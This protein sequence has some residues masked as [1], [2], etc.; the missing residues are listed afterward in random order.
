M[1][2]NL[3]R[4]QR[5]GRYTLLVLPSRAGFC[6]YEQSDDCTL[7]LKGCELQEF[8]RHVINEDGYVPGEM[9]IRKEMY[10][11]LA[12]Y[13]LTLGLSKKHSEIRGLQM[14]KSRRFFRKATECELASREDLLTSILERRMD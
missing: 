12:Q 2:T 1:R 9:R 8:A 7:D 6:G 3:T 13:Y 14:E 5:F 10:L 4:P 11:N